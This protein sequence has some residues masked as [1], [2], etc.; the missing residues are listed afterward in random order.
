MLEKVMVDI[1]EEIMKDE[2]RR[3]ALIELC[4][5]ELKETLPG[6]VSEHLKNNINMFD[7]GS[8]VEESVIEPV[9]ETLRDKLTEKVNQ[10]LE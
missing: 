8:I 3:N 1:V 4:Y 7:M 9:M 10:I 2:M 6:I 5:L